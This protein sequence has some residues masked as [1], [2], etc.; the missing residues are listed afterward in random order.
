AGAAY[1][2]GDNSL[3]QLGV[4]TD[5]TDRA[6]PTLVAGT[7]AFRSVSAGYLHTC[8]V[9]TT[10]AA[11]C[12]GYNFFGQLGDGTG[13]GQ[14]TPKAVS[15]GASFS[16]LSAGLLHTCGVVAADSTARCWG[17]NSAGQLGI[18]GGPSQFT[19]TPVADGRRFS[20]VG[21]GGGHTCGIV[22][23]GSRDIYCWGENESGQLGVGDTTDRFV[24]VEITGGLAFA[25][26]AVGG[27]FTCGIA[28]SSAAYCWGDNSLGQLGNGGT[29]DQ[30]GP[31]LVT[32][33][34]SFV[35]LVA[36]GAHNCGIAGVAY[37]WGFNDSGQL[38]DGTRNG[39]LV[40][41]RVTGQANPK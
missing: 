23:S 3:G 4:G 21:A 11:Y 36:G 22:A 25:S 5:T 34:L 8:G 38:G 32:G 15:G 2:W 30:W 33:G 17:S 12:W 26:L 18:G 28:S 19:P 13:A 6:T 31:A 20:V 7:L 40:P 16:S 29:A 27:A 37:C 9:A 10:G 35:A 41:V 1:C 39:S 14:F 24:P